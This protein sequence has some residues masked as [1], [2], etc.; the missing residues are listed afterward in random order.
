MEPLI[1]AAQLHRRARCALSGRASERRAH[2][3]AG[4]S[5]AWLGATQKASKINKFT[6]SPAGSHA[7]FAPTVPSHTA[8]SPRRTRPPHSTLP[9]E[10]PPPVGYPTLVACPSQDRQKSLRP[11]H[12]AQHTATA[13]APATATPTRG[14]VVEGAAAQRGGE[15]H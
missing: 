11:R 14:H 5:A 12:R 1:T 4:G 2:A 9:T 3:P 10:L 7:P 13:P 8:D 15:E 6:Y